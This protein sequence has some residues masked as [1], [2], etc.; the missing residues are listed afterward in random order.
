MNPMEDLGPCACQCLELQGQNVL[1]MVAIIGRVHHVK[2]CMHLIETITHE[3]KL[4]KKM[5]LLVACIVNSNSLKCPIHS[6]GTPESMV[7]SRAANMEFL[8]GKQW[9]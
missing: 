3:Q 4:Q 1:I 2:L 9:N 5:K 6:S 7:G 8:C